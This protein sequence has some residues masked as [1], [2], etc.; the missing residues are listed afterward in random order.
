MVNEGSIPSLGTKGVLIIFLSDYI[1]QVIRSERWD[2][3]DS[4]PQIFPF[5]NTN[6]QHSLK[7]FSV[8]RKTTENLVL[9]KEV[10]Q[11]LILNLITSYFCLLVSINI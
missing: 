7:I 10:R 6:P 3:C 4:K 8:V 2:F 1:F 5:H 11:V 9:M